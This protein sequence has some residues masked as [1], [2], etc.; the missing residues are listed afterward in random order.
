[1]NYRV[2]PAHGMALCVLRVTCAAA[3]TASLN[4]ALDKAMFIKR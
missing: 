4:I 3:L 2:K 1:M